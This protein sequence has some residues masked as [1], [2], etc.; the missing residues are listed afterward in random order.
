[1]ATIINT[2]QEKI[3]VLPLTLRTP[4]NISWLLF[5]FFLVTSIIFYFI[6]QPEIPLFYTLANKQAQLVP[7][8]YVF[9]FPTISFVINITHFFILKSLQK[10]ST[11][12]LRLFAGTTIALQILLGLA[13]IRIILITL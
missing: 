11:V 3:K 6:F 5:L 8:I 13:L 1:M 2:Q 9:L 12:L 10:F 4:T 7:K